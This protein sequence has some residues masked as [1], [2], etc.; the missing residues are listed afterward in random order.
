VER[1]GRF[2]AV[3]EALLAAGKLDQPAFELLIS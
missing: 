2:L 1:L 3:G